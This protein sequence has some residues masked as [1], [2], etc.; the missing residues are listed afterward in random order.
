MT[1]LRMDEMVALRAQSGEK[2]KMKGYLGGNLRE[3][4]MKGTKKSAPVF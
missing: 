3:K 4:K 1:A 2:K